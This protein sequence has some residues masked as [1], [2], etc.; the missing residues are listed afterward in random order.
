MSRILVTGGAGYIG[1]HCVQSLLKQGREV[2]VYDNLSTGFQEALPAGV[3]FIFGD[4]RDTALLGRVMK[5]SKVSSVIHFAAKLLVGE[6]VEK[7]LEYYENNVG[8]TLSVLKACESAEVHQLIFS[9]TAAVYGEPKEMQ[10]LVGESD[11][12]APTSPY[13]TSKYFSEQII[14][15][16]FSQSN[17]RATIL[18]Y[19]NVAGAASDL[20]N[21]SRSRNATHL[22]KIC[23]EV[24]LGRRSLVQ[25]YGSDYSTP[26]GTGVRD[27][28]HIEDLVDAHLLALDYLE[29]GGSS[30]VFNCGYGH[31]FSVLDVLKTF[32]QIN[33]EQIPYQLVGRRPG[34]V[35]S[36]VADVSKIKKML[37]YQPKK[38]S[39]E[40]ICCDALEWEKR[41]IGP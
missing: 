29:N 14:Q 25:V 35:A 1:S 34:D 2:I 30:E 9:S 26:D 21:G 11:A 6:S 16:Y 39:L 24:S 36:I 28:I 10:N 27:Y 18:R 22:I 40:V 23:S 33:G 7:P 3:K 32:S 38:D 20:S 41:L 12:C 5:D 8:G 37:Q 13:G 31:G 15:D 4:V 17:I 19:F